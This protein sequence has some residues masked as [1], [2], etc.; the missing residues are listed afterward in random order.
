MFNNLHSQAVDL[1]KDLGVE[2]RHLSFVKTESLEDATGSFKGDFELSD[3]DKYGLKKHDSIIYY[4]ESDT[5]EF[6][7][8]FDSEERESFENAVR[9]IAK[10]LETDLFR[11]D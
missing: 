6:Y 9:R 10:Y 1:L 3:V 8:T 11:D 5:I 2:Q 4:Q 7:A